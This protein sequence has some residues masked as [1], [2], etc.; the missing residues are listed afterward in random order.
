MAPLGKVDQV[1]QPKESFLIRLERGNDKRLEPG[2]SGSPQAA[3]A[4]KGEEKVRW[5]ETKRTASLKT[6]RFQNF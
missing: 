1:S 6:F 5:G 4:R 3:Y 2:S